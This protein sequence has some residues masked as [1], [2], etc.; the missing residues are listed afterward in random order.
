MFAYTY[1]LKCLNP[2]LKLKTNKQKNNIKHADI[3]EILINL[4]QRQWY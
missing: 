3:A 1:C 4:S 2:R